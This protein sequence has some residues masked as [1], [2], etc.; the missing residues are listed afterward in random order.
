MKDK[1]TYGEKMARKGHK[2]AFYK[3][4]FI[5]EH[6]LLSLHHDFNALQLL[7]SPSNLA[8]MMQHEKLESRMSFFLLHQICILNYNSKAILYS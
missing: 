8:H 3:V 6:T 4:N 7:G 5:S 2:K 1:Y